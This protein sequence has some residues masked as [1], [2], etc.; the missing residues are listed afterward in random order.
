M[1]NK[2]LAKHIFTDGQI[3]GARQMLNAIK[4]KA[5]AEVTFEMYWET[6]FKLNETVED[7][8]EIVFKM[9]DNH[10]KEKQ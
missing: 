8:D 1:I 5:E 10:T 9:I 7:L 2:E 6:I 4:G 3:I